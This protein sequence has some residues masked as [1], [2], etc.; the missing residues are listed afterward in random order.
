[1]REQKKQGYDRQNHVKTLNCYLKLKLHLTRKLTND[2]NKSC[3]FGQA[4]HINAD[5]SRDILVIP[6]N[7]E[8]VI[9]E[10][11]SQL[12]SKKSGKEK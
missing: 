9:A 7:E 12:L 11:T 10:Q 4:G 1:M 2:K 5:N 8:W 3:R 6:T